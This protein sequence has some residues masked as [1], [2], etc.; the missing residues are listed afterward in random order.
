MV[1]YVDKLVEFT[2]CCIDNAEKPPIPP[3]PPPE[4]ENCSLAFKNGNIAAAA[5][6]EFGDSVAD[7]AVDSKLLI[8]LEE[9]EVDMILSRG[10][11]DGEVRLEVKLEVNLG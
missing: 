7:G 11:E 5:A 6:A 4:R 3:T 8:D 1:H 10:K 9:E 2:T